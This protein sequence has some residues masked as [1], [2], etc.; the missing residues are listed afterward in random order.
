MPSRSST[1]ATPSVKIET[2]DDLWE[3]I[4]GRLRGEWSRLEA[5]T[6]DGLPDSFGL[7]RG[8]TWWLELKVG[9][10]SL[11][12]LRPSQRR[13]IY[14]AQARDVPVWCCF[15]WRHRPVFFLRTDFT[16]QVA[17]EWL[18]S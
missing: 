13:F 9:K 1:S 14:S 18:V 8:R 2:E 3:A 16:R 17:P 11:E 15:G 6:P 5:I 10:P 4:R 7:W 12:A